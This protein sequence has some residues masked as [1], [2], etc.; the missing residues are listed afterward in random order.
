[1]LLREIRAHL[2]YANVMATIAVF[3]ALG[4]NPSGATLSGTTRVAA[5]DGIATFGCAIVADFKKIDDYVEHSLASAQ[6]A[7]THAFPR[8]SGV[9]RSSASFDSVAPKHQHSVEPS[10]AGV[11]P[12]LHREATLPAVRPPF[13]SWSR[14]MVRLH[15][16][17]PVDIQF[18]ASK[19]NL[20]TRQG[21]D[22]EELTVRAARPCCRPYPGTAAG[23][24]QGMDASLQ[25][26]RHLHARQVGVSLVR[27]LGPGVSLCCP[28]ACRPGRPSPAARMRAAAGASPSCRGAPAR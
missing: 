27:R 26:G 24:Q 15:C 18:D 25:R 9:S 14:D 2:T 21:I 22:T 19:R 17:V 16:D 4:N 20:S 6:R 23:P 1:M 11:R 12:V 8:M 13:A 3:I 7:H 5:V 28:G 10:F